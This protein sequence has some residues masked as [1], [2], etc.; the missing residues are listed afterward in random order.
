MKWEDFQTNLSSGYRSL[1]SSQDFTDVTLA[2][3]D[4]QQVEAHKVILSTSSPF[5]LGLLQRTQHPHPVIYMRCLSY[6][7]LVALLDFI[8]H[9]EVSLEVE[10]LE[11]FLKLG[12]EL[13]L[14]GLQGQA[15][16]GQDKMEIVDGEGCSFL[17]TASVEEQREEVSETVLEQATY[18]TGFYEKNLKSYQNPEHFIANDGEVWSC[19]KCGKRSRHKNILINHVESKHLDNTY[20]CSSCGIVYKCKDSVR[21]HHQMKHDNSKIPKKT[22]NEDIYIHKNQELDIKP[23]LLDAS[24]FRV[25]LDI[26][27]EII[28]TDLNQKNDKFIIE[29]KDLAQSSK[30]RDRDW[31]EKIEPFLVMV[32]KDPVIFHCKECGK[33]SSNKTQMANHVECKHL[34]ASY[35]CPKCGK[36][37]KCKDSLKKHKIRRCRFGNVE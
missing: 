34:I 20:P 37:F 28:Q 6:V 4:G 17:T 30:P 11:E 7:T 3:E 1:R 33:S 9:G 21:K 16:S 25:M 32:G 5:F 35:Q 36:T 8:Y 18:E 24:G 23:N 10:E 15:E 22:N 29:E 31:Y 27:K 13:K 2:C 14:V 19:N 26:P 12:H